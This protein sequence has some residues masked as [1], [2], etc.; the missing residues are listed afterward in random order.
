MLKEIWIK[1][2]CLLSSTFMI[3][4][5][6]NA[7]TPRVIITIAERKYNDL[8]PNASDAGVCVGGVM[9]DADASTVAELVVG[10]SHQIRA[11]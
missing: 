7:P 8:T 5:T 9:I 3:D 6:E 10:V 2:P 4:G 1:P 11:N